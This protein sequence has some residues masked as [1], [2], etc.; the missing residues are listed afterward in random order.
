[1]SDKTNGQEQKGLST[2]KYPALQTLS[3]VYRVLAWLAGISSIIVIV[4][5]LSMLNNFRTKSAGIDLIIQGLI[6]GVL[7]VILCLAIS[8]GIKLFIDL[9]YN[10]RVQ[11]RLLTDLLEKI[12]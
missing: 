5:G 8:Q 10:T 2:E 4:Y 1:M 3:G 9:E 7:G 12:N 11:N 6:Y